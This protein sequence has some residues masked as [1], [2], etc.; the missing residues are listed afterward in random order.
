[1]K[2]HKYAKRDVL[3]EHDVRCNWCGETCTEAYCT[4]NTF[5]GRTVGTTEAHLCKGCWA[6]LTS[7]FSIKPSY[8]GDE[9]I[10]WDDDDLLQKK[11]KQPNNVTV[12]VAN[13]SLNPNN[14]VYVYGPTTSSIVQPTGSVSYPCNGYPWQ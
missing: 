4:L 1:V 9:H 12:T 10:I 13:N 3:E 8:D 5:W 7:L 6:R 2:R 11:I 14:V